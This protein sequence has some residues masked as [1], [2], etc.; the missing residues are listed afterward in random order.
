MKIL[1]VGGF[2][3]PAASA[4]VHSLSLVAEQVT[5]L[6]TLGTQRDS[7]HAELGLALPP[8]VTG[9]SIDEG[10]WAA[11][12]ASL[13]VDVIFGWWG[14][15]IVPYLRRCRQLLPRSA[16]VLC[17]DTLPDAAW[18]PGE[19]KDLIGHRRGR[20]VV[21][22]FVSAT[23]AM[24]RD[25]ERSHP[26]SKGRPHVVVPSCFPP[27]AAAGSVDT[28]PS[29]LRLADS[30]R[31]RLVFTGRTDALFHARRTTRKDQ[32]GALLTAFVNAGAEVFV[33]SLTE[34]DDP[35]AP[36]GKY[37]RFPNE[38]VLSGRYATY[39]SQFD[40]QLI[41]YNETNSVIRRRVRNGLSTRLAVAA[42]TTSAWVTSPT[43]A[44]SLRE[45]FGPSA[46]VVEL[47][48]GLSLSAV[49]DH[50]RRTTGA[51]VTVEPYLDAL[52]HM[53]LAAAPT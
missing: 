44:G 26:W 48:P 38:D 20:A 35:A 18:F 2:G 47:T 1:F 45:T 30:A 3:N 28:L 34:P 53:L 24:R 32:C 12:V 29:D 14:Y 46:P 16:V 9:K 17:L 36:F 27:T 23:V 10:D 21:T 42:L 33:P 43:S 8:H 13:D 51:P 41:V 40:G 15:K 50:A 7:L 52:Q 37:P 22:G 31:P 49:I 4:W 6:D 39:L 11:W 25:F 19:V 5:Y